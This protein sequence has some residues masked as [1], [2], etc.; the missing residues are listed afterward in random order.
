MAI[1]VEDGTGKED[2][3]SYTS[4][5]FADAYF[6]DR[7]VAEWTGD[8]ATK[9]AAL[10]RATDYI[11]LRFG[12]QFLGRR[13]FT[14]QSLAFPRAADAPQDLPRA[15]QRATAEYALRALSGALAPDLQTDASGV[16]VAARRSK[17]G[18]VEESVEYANAGGANVTA[19][20]FRPY[21]AADALLAPLL[22][23]F[24]LRTVRA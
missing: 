21:P 8:E 14:D 11:D 23:P 18:P 19:A 9:G 3:N 5:A 15:L 6:A 12:D 7:N 10:V 16:A 4:V 2:A 13:Q 1:I 22:R 17:V 20:L 24:R